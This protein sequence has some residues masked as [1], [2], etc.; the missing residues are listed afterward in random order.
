MYFQKKLVMLLWPEICCRN[1]THLYQVAYGKPGFITHLFTD[2]CSFQDPVDDIKWGLTVRGIYQESDSVLSGFLSSLRC[3]LW[4]W[5]ND[6]WSWDSPSS[7]YSLKIVLPLEG[8]KTKKGD[9]Q[10]HSQQHSLL[11]SPIWN[12]PKV[13]L[14]GKKIV[15]Y[16]HYVALKMNKFTLYAAT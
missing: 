11:Q 2:S 5:E 13:H 8:L 15:T 6:K 12:K 16:L 14:G 7:P 9:E 10:A 1:L 3:Y 4:S